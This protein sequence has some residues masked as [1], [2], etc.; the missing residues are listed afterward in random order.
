M[1]NLSNPNAVKLDRHNVIEASAGTGKT[2]TITQLVMRLLVEQQV[3]ITQ[4]LLVT[5]T[6]KATAE[7]KERIQQTIKQQ[8]QAADLPATAASVLHQALQDIGQ[9]SVFTIHGFCQRILREYAFEQGAIFDKSLIDD[10][11]VFSQQLRALK[12]TWPAIAGIKQKIAATGLSLTQLDEL[13]LDLASQVRAHDVI[14]PN[15]V[16]QAQDQ[17]QQLLLQLDFSQLADIEQQFKALQGVSTRVLTNRWRDKVMPVVAW[18]QSCQGLAPEDWVVAEEL[19]NMFKLLKEQFKPSERHSITAAS[20]A[21]LVQSVFAFLAQL[22]QA[23]QALQ[24]IAMAENYQLIL[25]MVVE[26]QRRA[27]QYKDSH[28]YI[29]YSDMTTDLA[30]TLATEASGTEQPLTR[31][32]RRKYQVA[33]IDEFQ[34]TDDEQWSIFKWLFA[35]PGLSRQLIVIGDPKQSIYGFR[36][37]DLRSY[38][39]AKA[40]LLHQVGG[41]GHRLAV[42]YRSWPA[43]SAQ[44]N[45]FFTFQDTAHAAWYPVSDVAVDSPDEDTLKSNGGP[46]V[47]QDQTGFG[48]FNRLPIEGDALLID[49]LKRQV[50]RQ[51][52]LTIKHRLLGQLRFVLKG[53]EKQL[54]AADICVL[55]RTKKDAQFIE[56]ALEQLDVPF[57][58]Y[59]KSQLYQSVAAIHLQLVLTALAY[60]NTRQHV[61]NAWLSLFFD[62]KVEQLP[63]MQQAMLPEQ[64]QLWL[65]LK[66]LAAQQ[67]WIGVFH[68]LLEESGCMNRLYQQGHWRMQA[69]L[70]QICTALLQVALAQNMDAHAVLH[71][72]LQLRTSSLLS[73]EDWQQKDSDLPA[74][75]IMTMHTSKGLEFPVVFLLGGFGVE[76]PP[77]YYARYHEAGTGARVY[78]LIDKNHPLQQAETE[79]ENKRLYYVAMTR[80]IFKLF[81]P[82]FDEQTHAAPSFYQTAITARLTAAGL[83]TYPDAENRPAAAQLDLFAE[84]NKPAQ[85]ATQL[86]P[87]PADL[88][89]RKRTIHSFSSLQRQQAGGDKNFGDGVVLRLRQDDE[90][91]TPAISNQPTIPGGA[92]VGNVLHGL[93]EHVDFAQVISHNSLD[94]LKQD[95]QIGA[96]INQ[97]MAHYLLPNADIKDADGQVVS[98]YAA[99]L[100]AW[101]WH[102]LNKPIAVLGGLKI[103]E[104]QASDRRHELSFHWSHQSQHLTGFIDLLFRVTDGDGSRYYL[105]DWKSN[106]SRHGYDQASLA[107]HIMAEHHYDEQYRLY[108]LAIK[109]WFAQLQLPTEQLAGVLY[110]FSRGMDCLSDSQE[111]I[112]YQDLQGARFSAAQLRTN[113]LQQLGGD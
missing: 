90:Q 79:A 31:Q 3:P 10:Y 77:T 46:L 84:A 16:S 12:R 32:L 81:M 15:S 9:A 95:A 102:T 107:Q 6:E 105:L 18:L 99:E 27:K 87:W 39:A 54:D 45:A 13:L 25:Q 52:A 106:I 62:V 113:L 70:K 86:L 22:K 48:D 111:G 42:N 92:Q 44:L 101:L 53:R 63:L 97:Q 56:Q 14:Y 96:L 35:Q 71:E 2:F 36:G 1:K 85:T 68:C 66:A 103:G 47:L 83:A 98:T 74:V 5:F 73:S 40:Y 112:F 67:D 34:D 4:I 38:E 23:V 17:A 65:R 41:Q 76:K 19:P 28:G 21:T 72:L 43:L 7:L 37:A 20:E 109:D 108:T 69:N 11:E 50:A 26:L 89:V 60:P 93:F 59:K 75:Q 30:N 49:E 94:S 55:V 58:F 33:L 82:F 100:S 78:D 61:N 110:V 88:A 8:L 24:A 57:S 64:N 29:S 80:A 104:I 91:A 51:M